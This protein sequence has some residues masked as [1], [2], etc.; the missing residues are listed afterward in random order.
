MTT[1]AENRNPLDLADDELDSYVLPEPPE[2]T[3]EETSSEGVNQEEEQEES[4]GEDQAAQGKAPE[5]KGQEEE[6]DESQEE[7]E[8]EEE[9]ETPAAK[10]PEKAEE[11]TPAAEKKEEKAVEKSPEAVNYKAEYE[12]IIGAP[13]KANGKTITVKSVDDAIALMQMG[14]D[15]QRKMVAM[16]PHTTILKTLEKAGL[17][18]QEK[19]NFLIDLSKNDQGAVGKLM[20]DSGIDP[21]DLNLEKAGD[22]KPKNHAVSPQEVELDNVLE[23]LQSTQ[24]YSKLIDVVGKQ[25]DDKSKQA[26]ADQPEL[27]HVINTH[28]EN[29]VYD[30]IASAMDHERMFGRLNGLSSLEAYRKIGDMLQA[31]GG[32]NHLGRQKVE[33]KPAQKVVVQKSGASSEDLNAR[34]R[35]ASGSKSV[36]AQNTKKSV[37]FNPLSMT[38]EEFAQYDKKLHI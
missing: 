12:K 10:K 11:K 13:I 38:D 19:I 14:A 17:L 24:T 2:D 3:D 26:I 22:Y 8:E 27:L 25:W 30:V 23:E 21:I 32:F 34:R 5:Q 1:P 7:D 31:N 37:D 15:Y 33:T 18:D 16:K 4:S 29:G 36:A 6:A 28:M 20:K 9:E 35:A